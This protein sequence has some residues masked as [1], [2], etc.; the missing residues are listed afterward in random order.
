MRGYTP[1][2]ERTDDRPTTHPETVREQ[3]TEEASDHVAVW[4]RWLFEEALGGS[5][6]PVHLPRR[7][8]RRLWE[9]TASD[10]VSHIRE[11]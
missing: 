2:A 10:R 11:R 8:L 5:P 3:H 4:Q 6:V 1:R 9:C 7:L